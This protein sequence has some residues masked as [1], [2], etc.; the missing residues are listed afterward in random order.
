MRFAPF[1]CAAV[2]CV[3][4]QPA[5]RTKAV[6]YQV[7]IQMEAVS[8][9][10]EYLV[11]SLP[12]AKGTLDAKDYLVVEVGF[13]GP[14]MSRL[15][16]SSDHFSLRINGRAAPIV[17]QTPGMVADSISFP[18][19]RPHLESAGTVEAG[20]G[21]IMV[22]PKP[23]VSRI[24]G[25]RNDPL[26]QPTVTQEKEKEDLVANRVQ[27]VSLREGEQMLPC[28][29]LIYFP[30]RGKTK[31]IHSLELL[32]DGPMGKASLKLLP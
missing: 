28:S 4:G 18:T 7:H 20:N 3:S 29:G 13:F 14:A 23:P 25:D 31:S 17:T 21:T 12:T 24:P 2:A 8:L 27:S 26:D 1:F 10:A 5:A 6:D 9:G 16:I 19:Q 30:Y 15:K 11:Q 32:Y 22:G